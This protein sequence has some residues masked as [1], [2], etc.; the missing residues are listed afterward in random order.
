MTA[1]HLRGALLL[2]A[3]VPLAAAMAAAV[4]RASHLKLYAD[5]E[6]EARG[7]WSDRRE[8]HIRLLPIPAWADPPC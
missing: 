7:C 1:Q 2:V 5:P 4:L 8:L 6:M 3:A